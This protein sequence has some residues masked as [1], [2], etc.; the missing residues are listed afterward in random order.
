MRRF[1]FLLG[2]LL[3]QI[4]VRPEVWAPAWVSPCAPFLHMSMDARRY[5]GPAPGTRPL[6]PRSVPSRPACDGCESSPAEPPACTRMPYAQCTVLRW[7]CRHL[8]SPIRFVPVDRPIIAVLAVQP[9]FVA[10]RPLRL[11][12][13][14]LCDCGIG[15]LLTRHVW[16]QLL[17]PFTEKISSG[18]LGP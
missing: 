11:Q 15:D 9:P 2:R 5:N 10:T 14:P 16:I 12:L 17:E 3:S 7:Q 6:H 18:A 1:F 8:A 13:I 4:T